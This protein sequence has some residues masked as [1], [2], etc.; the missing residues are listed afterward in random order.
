MS[1]VGHHDI[2]IIRDRHARGF[3]KDSGATF[4]GVLVT[5]RLDETAF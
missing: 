1:T 5:Q 4:H 3:V 2:S